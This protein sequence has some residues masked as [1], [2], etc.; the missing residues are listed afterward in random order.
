MTD[1]NRTR[2]KAVDPDRHGTNAEEIAVQLRGIL[3]RSSSSMVEGSDLALGIV[4]LTAED[5]VGGFHAT[6]FT[7]ALVATRTQFG[8]QAVKTSGSINH[9]VLLNLRSR[10][11]FVQSLIL[12]E[13][14]TER[15]TL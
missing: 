14:W 4:S 11:A 1:S 3:H 9:C 5:G 13:T 6:S 8:H 2:F 12:P 15:T 10:S 7:N